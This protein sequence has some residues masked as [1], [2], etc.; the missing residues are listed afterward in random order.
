MN[1]RPDERRKEERRPASGE[2]EFVLS[3]PLAVRFRGTLIDSSNSGFRVA[4]DCPA[5]RAGHLVRY[6]HAMGSG[7]ARVMWTRTAAAAM[8]A[9]F[10]VL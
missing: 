10:L 5:L 3:D 4:H 8:E 7:E 1:S 6:W 2:V 9:G